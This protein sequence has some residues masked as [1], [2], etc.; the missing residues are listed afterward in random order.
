MCLVSGDSDRAVA[1][2]TTNGSERL[3]HR[4]RLAST[5]EARDAARVVP[6]QCTLRTS[7]R[8]SD[9]MGCAT[10]WVTG[11]SRASPTVPI[12]ENVHQSLRMPASPAGPIKNSQFS[13]PLG[14]YWVGGY[15]GL[16]AYS[17]KGGPNVPAAGKYTPYQEKQV[18]KDPC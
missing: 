18:S 5:T 4:S 14:L 12:A 3:V 6:V 10:L 8:V 16:C 2:G 11:W 13:Y 15:S 17:L 9:E 1:V 7:V